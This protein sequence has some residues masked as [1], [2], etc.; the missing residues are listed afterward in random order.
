MRV[1]GKTL[2]E[3]GMTIEEVMQHLEPSSEGDEAATDT[4]V[5]SA[6]AF[7]ADETAQTVMEESDDE[8]QDE[9]SC[10]EEEAVH[11]ARAAEQLAVPAVITAAAGISSWLAVVEQLSDQMPTGTAG[12]GGV[13]SSG[14]RGAAGRCHNMSSRLQGHAAQIVI[15]RL[16]VQQTH[17]G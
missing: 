4:E 8:Q 12:G 11:A 2:T 17:H 3:L 6:S 9:D 5:A 16:D 7:A 15:E 1:N 10:E 13:S 14:S